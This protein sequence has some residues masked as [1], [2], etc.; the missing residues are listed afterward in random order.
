MEDPNMNGI[1]EDY[2]GPTEMTYEENAAEELVGEP[3]ADFQAPAGMPAPTDVPV[4]VSAA[5]R[6]RGSRNKPKVPPKTSAPRPTHEI[7]TLDPKKMTETERIA[8]IKFFQVNVQNLYTDFEQYKK[9]TEGAFEQARTLRE[10][11][12][13][14]KTEARAK[15][16]LLKQNLSTVY[17]NAL[18][19]TME[20]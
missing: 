4:P 19:I 3:M 12:E 6:P 15:I 13:R 14:I 20:D 18:L 9:N 7:Y 17:Q 8:V 2:E 16:G 5:P 1:P 10:Q 11:N